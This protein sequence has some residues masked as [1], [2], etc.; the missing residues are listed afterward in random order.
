MGLLSRS[1]LNG[2]VSASGRVFDDGGE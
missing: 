1:I 2:D